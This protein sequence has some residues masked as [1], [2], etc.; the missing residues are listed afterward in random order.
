[1]KQMDDNIGVVLKKLEEIGQLT[2]PLSSSPPTMAPGDQL[3]DGGVTFKGQK[4]EAWKAATALRWS[5]AGPASSGRARS[6]TSCSRPDWLP[7]LVDIAGGA[8]A[9]G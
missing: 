9:T 5:S 7:T 8:K 6:R 2:T 3:P 1:M 4:G